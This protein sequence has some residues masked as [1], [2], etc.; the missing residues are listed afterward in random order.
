MGPLAIGV[1]IGTL[2]L[3]EKDRTM[4]KQSRV[5]PDSTSKNGRIANS[6]QVRGSQ[7]EMH[8]KDGDVFYV[9]KDGRIVK[10][11]S[12]GPPNSLILSG[13]ILPLPKDESRR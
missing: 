9:R 4:S 10:V 1:N 11:P 8:R 3:Y 7:W 6:K 13:S 12:S 2:L 5:D